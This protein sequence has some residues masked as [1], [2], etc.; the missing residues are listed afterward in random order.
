MKKMSLFSLAMPFLI[1]THIIFSAE[2][3]AVKI[4]SAPVIDGS[5]DDVLWERAKQLTIKD[6]ASET[7]LSIRAVYDQKYLYFLVQY[8]DKTESRRHKPFVWNS[9]IEIY[10]VSTEREDTL[11]FKW[12]M[13]DVAT[14]LSL[15][16]DIEY[17]A[18]IWYWK[19]NRTDPAGYADDKYHVYS[20]HSGPK[21]KM[22]TSREGAIF[23]LIRKGDAGKAAYQTSLKGLYEGDSVNS[24]EVSTPS[25]SRGDIKAKGRW[26]NGVWTIEFQRK[27]VTGNTDD[28]QFSI[29]KEFTFALSRYEIAGRAV[30]AK[31]SQP[32]H[33]AG[34]VGA[35]IHLNFE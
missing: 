2:L 10:Q 17:R 4:A 22:L 23:Y 29:D 24:Y 33:G 27:L 9:A 6:G 12:N 20:R 14:N 15:S 30:N 34:E 1:F 19:A 32:L 18:D 3:T 31:L 25:G 11:I 8:Q 26:H 35:V 28:V 5:V 21:S 7:Q 16:S 13:G